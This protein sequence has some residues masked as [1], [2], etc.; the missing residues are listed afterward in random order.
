MLSDITA[1]AMSTEEMVDAVFSWVRDEFVLLEGPEFDSGGVRD[2][3]L[4]HVGLSAITTGEATDAEKGRAARDWLLKDFALLEGP[5]FHFGGGV[6][7]LK[8]VINSKEATAAEKALLMGTLLAKLE[9]PFAAA[10]VRTPVLGPVDRQDLDDTWMIE[11]GRALRL[12]Q[13]SFGLA[14]R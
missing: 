14:H 7:D 13:K 11:S 10:A 1:G 3:D 9:I 4:N 8:D 6:R 2:L 12:M 5:E